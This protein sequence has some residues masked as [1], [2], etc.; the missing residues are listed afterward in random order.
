MLKNLKVDKGVVG[1]K[2]GLSE[3]IVNC[4]FNGNSDQKFCNHYSDSADFQASTFLSEKQSIVSK[5]EKENTISYSP[6]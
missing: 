2:A 3:E 5:Y 1:L 6:C 4:Y